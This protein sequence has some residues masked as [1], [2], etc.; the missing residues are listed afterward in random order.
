MSS[1]GGKGRSSVPSDERGKITSF[2]S[3]NQ[4]STSND[5][6]R[7]RALPAGNAD[8]KRKRYDVETPFA[9]PSV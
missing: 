8:R 5:T 7:D 2:F 6:G 9:Q 3:S 1:K 4:L